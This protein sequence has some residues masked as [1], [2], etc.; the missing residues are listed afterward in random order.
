MFLRELFQKSYDG[1]RVIRI[2]LPA[3]P[4]FGLPIEFVTSG[5]DADDMIY[6]ALARSSPP[7]SV[8]NAADSDYANATDQL[9][10]LG[11]EV[12]ELCHQ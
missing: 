2:A 12:M 1:E 4:H 3:A 10:E 11:V 8:V 5:F 9:S 6:V 7:S